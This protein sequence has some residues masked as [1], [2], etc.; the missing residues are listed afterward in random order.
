[1]CILHNIDTAF[2]RHHTIAYP[3]SYHR[4][5]TVLTVTMTNMTYRY[6]S[7][8]STASYLISVFQPS[9]LKTIQ[10]LRTI[11]SATAKRKSWRRGAGEQPTPGF[12]TTTS[13]TF[14]KSYLG[15]QISFILGRGCVDMCVC[16]AQHM[17]QRVL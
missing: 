8:T 14:I 16:S 3:A 11:S 7:I 17:P 1:M 10:V 12:P 9:G 15:K 6:I 5:R 4:P 13:A 2:A